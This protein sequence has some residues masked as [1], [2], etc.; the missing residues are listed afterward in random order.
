MKLS[1]TQ[2]EDPL[3]TLS[4]ASYS[5]PQNVDWIKVTTAMDRTTPW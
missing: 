5:Q 4:T 1:D 3:A 2:V